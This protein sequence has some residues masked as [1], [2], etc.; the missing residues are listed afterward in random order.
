MD[1][2]SS[3]PADEIKVGVDM[4]GNHPI[5]VKPLVRTTGVE[6]VQPKAEG[7]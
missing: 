1:M 6:P 3:D 5:P 2:A 7:F 4:G